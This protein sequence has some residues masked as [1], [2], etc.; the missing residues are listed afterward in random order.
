[1]QR[2]MRL[3][4]LSVARAAD[5]GFTFAAG[6]ILGSRERRRAELADRHAV[7]VV[8]SLGEMK[9]VMMKIGQM[10]SYL[11]EGMPEPVRQTLAS[12]QHDAPPME[13]DVAIAVVERELGGRLGR[14]FS[15]FDEVPVAAASIGQVHHAVTKGGREVAVK[16]Q[17]PG[18]AEAIAADLDNTQML[19]SIMSMM[20]SGLDPGP[21]VGELRARI[22]EEL[23]YRHE[24]K[25]QQL[26]VDFYR[27]HPHVHIPE[28]FHDLSADR[29]LTSEF[30]HGQRFEETVAESDQHRRDELA[31]II[32]RYVFRG[33]YRLGAFNGDPHPGNY[34]FEADGRIAFLDYGLVKYFSQSDNDEFERLIRSMLAGDAREFRAT[35]EEGKLLRTGAPFSDEELYEWFSHYYEIVLHEGPF[36]ITAEYASSMVRYNFDARTNKILKYANIPPTYA[37]TQRINLGLYAILARLRATANYRS[38]AEEIWPWTD[39]PPSTPLA[40][41]EATWLATK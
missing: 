31:E 6:A 26:F 40:Q 12:L 3:A 20:F 21:L 16:V 10:A 5:A 15:D 37:L 18:I 7:A 38:I 25:N 17:Y 22:G 1:M 27:G 2:S 30:V 36:S 4:R 14:F 32:F 9:G 13:G 34:L 19:G 29:V 35:L 39:A 11:D 24:A 8:G 28:V 41:E 33:L 23:D